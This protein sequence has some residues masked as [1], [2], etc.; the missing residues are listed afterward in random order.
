MQNVQNVRT[1]VDDAR[2]RNYERG[3]MTHRN[4]HT[5]SAPVLYVFEP[6]MRMQTMHNVNYWLEKMFMRSHSPPI[7]MTCVAL[8]EMRPIVR[9]AGR[10]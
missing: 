9:L 6:H 7:M 1:R 2:T 3:T 5:A 10:R 8:D 4:M